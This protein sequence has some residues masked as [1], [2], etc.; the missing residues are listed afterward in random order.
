[1][2]FFMLKYFKKECDR[3]DRFIGKLLLLF[4]FII[5]VIP[6]ED[7]T[8]PV[9]ALLCTVTASAFAEV[10]GRKKYSVIKFFGI[11]YGLNGPL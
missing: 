6:Y 4:I 3:M 11:I 5:N 1:M 8:L 10:A 9:I 7:F 2:S